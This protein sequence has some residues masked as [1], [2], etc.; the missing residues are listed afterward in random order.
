M[1]SIWAYLWPGI[2]TLEN[3]PHAREKKDNLKEGLM[4]MF[5]PHFSLICYG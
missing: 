1:L 2:L 5:F 4:L 3:L